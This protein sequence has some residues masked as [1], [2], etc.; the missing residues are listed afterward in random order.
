[1]SANLEAKKVLIEEIKDKIKRSKSITVVDFS[2]VTVAEDTKLRRD[3]RKAG[4]DY[5]V[6]KNKLMV[7]ALKELGVEFNE[8]QFQGLNA[9]AFSYKDEVSAPKVVV[10]NATEIKK[11]EIR[12][13]FVDGKLASKEE[14]ETLAKIP[15]RE[16]LISMLLGTL[17]A[18]IAALARGLNAIATK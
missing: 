9:V 16:V 18:P 15:S 10:D 12:F 5:K 2:K 17:N 8:D 7:R 6:Y 11:L 13:G 1:M 4:A 3:F 14:L